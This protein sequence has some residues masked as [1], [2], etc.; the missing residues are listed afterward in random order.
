MSYYINFY[1]TINI[2]A[3]LSHSGRLFSKLQCLNVSS[4]ILDNS[5]AIT[6]VIDAIP[7]LKSIDLSNNNVSYTPMITRQE[8]FS[9]YLESI[10]AQASKFIF[11]NLILQTTSS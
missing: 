1:R 5:T 7:S 6:K 9:I 10:F 4:N 2:D 3:E 11:I 8:H